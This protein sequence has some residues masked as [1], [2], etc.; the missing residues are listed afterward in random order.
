MDNMKKQRMCYGKGRSRKNSVSKCED[1]KLLFWPCHEAHVSRERHHARLTLRLRTVEDETYFR[2]SHTGVGSG[3]YA[4]DLT[5][6]TIYVEG[7]LICISPLT[8]CNT[9]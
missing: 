7:I 2:S 9:Y 5:P 6:P 3:G 8:V 1:R 4:G